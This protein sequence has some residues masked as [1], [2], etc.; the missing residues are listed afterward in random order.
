MNHAD[1]AVEAVIVTEGGYTNNPADSGGETNWGITVSIARAYGYTAPMVSMTRE[2]AKAIYL[3]R[4]WHSQRLDQV[5]A[6]SPS[7]AFEIF[8]TGVNQGE[9]VGAR[10][11][12]RALNVLNKGGTLY[13]DLEADGRIGAVTIAAFR[14]FFNRRGAEGI[15]V[16]LRAQNCMQGSFYVELAEKRTK[17]EAFVY[18]WLLNRVSV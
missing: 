3:S 1:S 18:G 10:Y 13:P 6:I 17:D 12:Q 5:A 15:K 11:F 2:Q 8:D 9:T 4:F 16:L 7:V 14:E